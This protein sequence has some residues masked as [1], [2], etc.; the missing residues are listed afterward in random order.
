[1]RKFA[2]RLML[3]LLCGTALAGCATSGDTANQAKPDQTKTAAAPAPQTPAAD[4]DS[5]VRQAQLLRLAGQYD[6]AIHIL[7]QLMLV[8]SDDARVVGEYGKTLAEMGRA[9]DA[10]QFLGRTVQLQPQDW[11]AY[12]ALGVAYDQLGDQV[13]AR[14]A[15]EHALKLRPEE[16]SV[17]NNYALSRML[18]KDPEGARQLIGR[19]RAAGGA[20]DPK[21]ARN[22][23]MV[24]QLAPAPQEPAKAEAAPVK[25]I[26]VA[27]A[28]LPEVKPAPAAPQPAPAATAN[29]V[30]VTP[31]VPTSM[32]RSLQPQQAQ[33]PVQAPA[34]SVAAQPASASPA[35]KPQSAGQTAPSGIASSK[36][37]ASK[38]DTKLAGKADDKSAGPVVRIDIKPPVDGKLAAKSDGKPAAVVKADAKPDAK[39][40]T[41]PAVKTADAQNKNGVP[42]LRM[43]A[44]K[45]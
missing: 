38:P 14:L 17:L 2:P 25:K 23:A 34:A 22:I 31:R 12:S 4:L 30:T 15:Y 3:L 28:P 9:Q 41:A 8:A 26:A 37:A 24:D 1:M 44:D 35:A 13:S 21:I 18:A 29:A 45:Y 32:P 42:A 16:P 7:S 19:A 5:G 10:V 43:A 11:S 20:A 27:A 39:A 33:T 6:G 40:P 36:P